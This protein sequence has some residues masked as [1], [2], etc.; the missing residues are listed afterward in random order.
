MPPVGL[1]VNK[2]LTLDPLHLTTVPMPPRHITLGI[3]AL[4]LTA[5]G[6][7]AYREWGHEPEPPLRLDRTDEVGKQTARWRVY[8]NGVNEGPINVGL[9]RSRRDGFFVLFADF[10]PA[11]EFRVDGF[12][13]ENLET[14]E[15]ATVQGKL[16]SL[17]CKITLSYTVWLASPDPIR[18]LRFRP[19]P[20]TWKRSLRVEASLDGD[21]LS[22]R[23]VRPEAPE[24][25]KVVQAPGDVLNLLH[26]LHR[27]PELYEGR[28]WRVLAFDP[29]V[30]VLDGG[31]QDSAGGFRELEATTSLDNIDDLG[32]KTV[33][34]W[35]VDL[36]DGARVRG[37]VWAR[38]EDGL[39]LRQRVYYEHGQIK[40]ENES[41][42]AP[43]RTL[44]GLTLPQR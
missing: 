11:P 25:G 6:W 10:S 39:V 37:S 24:Y 1:C 17:N 12:T 5:V 21:R 15:R 26:P 3:V 27:M 9:T 23:V 22:Y 16:R 7:M 20:V 35:R 14:R 8:L 38:V 2:K 4:W 31:S 19:F 41:E 29:L 13:V 34:C 44:P 32:T 40:L 42:H 33:A 28:T 30:W 43:V 18:F 36:R